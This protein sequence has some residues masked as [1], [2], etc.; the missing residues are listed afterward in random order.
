MSL[1]FTEILSLIDRNVKSSTAS[2]TVAEKTADINLAL[3]N[4]W[5]MIFECGGTW[6]FDDYNHTDYP[7]ITTDLV[8]GQRDYAFTSDGSSNLILDIYKVM[9]AGAD[10]IYREIYPVDQ[11]S[12]NNAVTNVDTFINGQDKTGTPTRYDKTANGIF[13]DLIPNYNLTNGLKVFINRE[14]SYFTTSD[15]TKKAGFSGL[16]HEYLALR[17]SYQYAY[18]NSLKNEARLEREMFKI[19]TAIRKHYGN[20]ERDVRR[21]MTANREDNH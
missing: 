11:Q 10:G 9:V 3:A 12:P 15:T 4:V 13:L 20:R 1:T 7:I 14:G 5:S 19:E 8:S 18:R 17:P 2:Y 6:Q 16:F 21:G